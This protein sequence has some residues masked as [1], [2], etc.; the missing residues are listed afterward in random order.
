MKLP[1]LD[2]L[3]YISH[4]FQVRLKCEFGGV[5]TREGL[6]LRGPAGFGEFAPF[7]HHTPEH[8][9]LWLA[10][11]IEMAYDPVTE[12][13]RAD[14]PINAIIPMVSTAETIQFVEQALEQGIRVFK[15]KCGSEDFADDFA[16]VMAV[17]ETAP[18]SSIR[19][20]VNGKWDVQQAKDRIFE[21]NAFATLEYVEQPVKTLEDMKQLR[22][23]V[24]VPLAIDENIRLSK[25][26]KPKDLQMAADIAI[27]K[28]IPS[29]GVRRAL[30]QAEEIDMP[31]VVSGSMDTSVGL[32]AG[33]RLAANV[34]E[35]HGACGL[36]T[37]NLLET[38]IATNSL[39]PRDGYISVQNVEPNGMLLERYAS[40]M[41]KEARQSCY[42]QLETCYKILE[43]M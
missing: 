18:L 26:V 3:I 11:A 19:I 6:S 42:Q 4:P 37:G 25:E 29:G 32:V 41:S 36:G 12:F 9:A 1:P 24:D 21:L 10:A 30:E 16:R 13:S 2:E 27:L 43:Q 17:R 5:N 35:L 38:D 39:L 31:I 34:K 22:N 28:A 23:L 8:A 7:G 33:L 15:V 20:D 40:Q 14:I